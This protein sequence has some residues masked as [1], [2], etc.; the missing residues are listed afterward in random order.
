MDCQEILQTGF[1]EFFHNISQ[2]LP[3]VSSQ[4]IH[5]T[6]SVAFHLS[7]TIFEVAKGMGLDIM[8]IK[9]NPMYGLV[10]FHQKKEWK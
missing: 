10:E 1:I 3:N 4:K 7:K 6:G 8:E 9:Q 2:S 5:L